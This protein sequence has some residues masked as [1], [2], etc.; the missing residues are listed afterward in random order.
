MI[1]LYVKT[2]NQTGLKYFGKTTK[3]DPHKYRGSGKYWSKHLNVHGNDVC[4]EIVGIFQSNKDCSEFAINFSKKHNIVESKEWANLRME[5]GADGA[6]IGN[7]FSLETIEKMRQSKIGKKP[8]EY[9]VEIAKMKIGF[10]QSNYQKQRVRET[11]EASWVVTPP[12]GQSINIV[13]LT[14]F[15]RENGLDQGN[16]VKVSKGQAKQHKGWTCYKIT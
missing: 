4:T 14:K 3:K 6:P 16:M 15:C 8:R 5:N 10:K 9:Y 11:F 12:N 1:Y 2:H 7:S 13:N